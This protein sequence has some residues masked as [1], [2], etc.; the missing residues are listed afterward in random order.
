MGIAR[1]LALLRL[2]V[3]AK[4]C[5]QCDKKI[6]F[7][8]SPVEGIYCS[9]ECQTAAKR[10]IEENQRRAEERLVEE[11]RSAR[12]AEERAA[13]E[14]ERISVELAVKNQCPKCGT[15]WKYE[16]RSEPEALDH[17]E[18]SKCGFTASFS[19]IERCPTCTGMSLVVGADG[20]RCPRCKTRRD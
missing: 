8:K 14:A 16:P 18:C 13:A 5:V 7:F 19:D 6:G 15:T 9:T 20:A 4:V 3:M 10:D 2:L 11:E 12:E 1:V 17:G